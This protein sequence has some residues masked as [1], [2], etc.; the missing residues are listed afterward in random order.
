M[1]KILIPA[2]FAGTVLLGGCASYG[3]GGLLGGILGGDTYGY[4]GGSDL[5]KRAARACGEEGSRF[6]PV[7]VTRVDQQDSDYLYV[8]GRIDTRDYDR[9]EFTCVYRADG[10]IVDFKLR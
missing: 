8:Y 2:A 7:E 10:R 6:G 4:S 9:D 3:D 1:R 5:Q